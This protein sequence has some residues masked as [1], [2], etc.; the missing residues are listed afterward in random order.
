M[1]Q[2]VILD[3]HAPAEVYLI[4]LPSIVDPMPDIFISYSKADH[5]LALKLSAFLESEGWSVWWDKSLSAADLYRDEIMKQL[6]AA[7]AVVTIWTPNSIKSDWVRAEAGR[8]KA[9][10]K[11]IPVKTPELTYADI[12]LPC[13]EMHTE[14]VA[15]TD[16]IRGT[17]VAQLAKPTI[18]VSQFSQITGLFKY[19]VLTWIGIV[20]SAITLFANLNGVLRLAHWAEDLVKHWHEWNQ[21]IWRWAFSWIGVEVPRDIVPFISFMLFTIIL[22]AG[23][24]LSV[25]TGGTASVKPQS[26]MPVMRKVGVFALGVLLY[27]VGIV[28]YSWLTSRIGETYTYGS[29]SFRVQSEKEAYALSVV[30]YLILLGLPIGYLLFFVKE[31]LL[32]VIASLLFFVMVG[33]LLIVPLEVEDTE[34]SF[35]IELPLF[36]FQIFWMAVILFSPLQQLTRRQSFIVLGVLTLIGL[37]EFLNLQQYLYSFFQLPS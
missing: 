24:N 6:A 28:A 27:L 10:G 36:V 33:C 14:N 26:V 17:I 8:A 1:S 15:S 3:A 30:L 18:P 16:L 23:A 22:I 29:M 5:A 21:I 11:L 12:P 13:G 7:R 20:G 31:R 34:S 2:V 19:Q 4:F 37:S 32:A 35:T 25:W 9:E